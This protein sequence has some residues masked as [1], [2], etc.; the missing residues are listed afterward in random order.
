MYSYANTFLGE[1]PQL[2]NITF[3]RDQVLADRGERCRTCHSG[4]QTSIFFV[5]VLQKFM[6][7][8]PKSMLGKRIPVRL[9]PDLIGQI[10]SATLWT[11][12]DFQKEKSFRES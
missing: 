4:K 2:Y 10:Q 1:L 8:G 7:Y 12:A 11:E 3:F 9:D 6:Y 5:D